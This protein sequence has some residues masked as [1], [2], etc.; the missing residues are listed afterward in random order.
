MTAQSIQQNWEAYTN[1]W[2]DINPSQRE[3]LVK[4]SVSDDI[5]FSN[6]LISGRGQVELIEAMAQFQRQFPGAYIQLKQSIIHHDQLLSGWTIYGKDGSELLTGYNYARA[7]AEGKL[8][9]MAG[10]FA[11]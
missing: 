11:A 7:N 4:I 6:P 5:D 10:F 8:L 9:H 1:A 3:H 2:A